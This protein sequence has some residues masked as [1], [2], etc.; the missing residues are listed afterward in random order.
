MHPQRIEAKKIITYICEGEIKWA[1]EI[2]NNL[3]IL[4][5]KHVL[6]NYLHF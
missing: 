3:E 6:M 2:E 5:K 1:Y 4:K